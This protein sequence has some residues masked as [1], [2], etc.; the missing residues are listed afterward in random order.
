M[1]VQLINV[2]IVVVE[3]TDLKDES[4][5]DSDKSWVKLSD[6]HIWQA[7]VF[8]STK[9]VSVTITVSDRHTSHTH[10]CLKA[11]HTR[12]YDNFGST[13]SDGVSKFGHRKIWKSIYRGLSQVDAHVAR[14]N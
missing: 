5:V 7:L 9:V 11:R 3:A 6:R 13:N 4:I 2:V 10:I 12:S 1:H 14:R 8:F